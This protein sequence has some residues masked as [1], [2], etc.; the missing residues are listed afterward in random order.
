MNP[1]RGETEKSMI[2][3][4]EIKELIDKNNLVEDYIDLDAQLTPNGFDLT[5][6]KIF[7]FSGAGS[8]DFSNR[9]RQLP[10]TEENTPQKSK[11]EDKYGW[12]QL[13]KGVY[14]VRTNE[15]VNIPNNLV[16]LAFSRTSLLRMGAFT[17]NGVWDAGFKGKSEFV[18]VVYNPCGIKIKQN[19]RV[20]QL[21]FLR[22]EETEKYKGI[23]NNLK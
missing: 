13:P 10:E 2:N 17:Q 16:A 21:V 15:T 18:L 5:V 11:P 7:K 4:A 1:L 19:A 3:K 23:Y 8:L 22:V 20:I 14:K 9:E 6:E 12:W